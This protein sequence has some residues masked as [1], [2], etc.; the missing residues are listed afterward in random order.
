MN[1]KQHISNIYIEIYIMIMPLLQLTRKKIIQTRPED[2]FL[3]S[4]DE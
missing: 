2:G 4:L 3:T 1:I